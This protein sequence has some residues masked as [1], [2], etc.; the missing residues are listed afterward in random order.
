MSLESFSVTRTSNMCFHGTGVKVWMFHQQCTCPLI[1]QFVIIKMFS[2]RNNFS[3]TP[4]SYLFI[5]TI[6]VLH[7]L[8]VIITLTVK[9]KSYYL[10]HWC[11]LF[12]PQISLSVNEHLQSE[13]QS[14]GDRCTPTDSAE[15][16]SLSRPVS[17][18]Y[19]TLQKFWTIV[20][21]PR[22]WKIDI[23]FV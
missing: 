9:W 18:K 16:K 8:I 10:N 19:T 1:F 20:T 4:A 12:H 21:K 15:S 2:V 3:S 13:N 6:S 5:T 11:V 7:T 17:N 23:N 22:P 14:S